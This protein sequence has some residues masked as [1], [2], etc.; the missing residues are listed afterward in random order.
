MPITLRAMN[1]ERIRREEQGDGSAVEGESHIKETEKV[2]ER[3]GD[4]ELDRQINII[5]KAIV[6][7]R[8]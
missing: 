8:W 2:E 1:T 3:S 7:S 4:S 6:G 5:N